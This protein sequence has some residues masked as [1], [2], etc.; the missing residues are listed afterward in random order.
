MPYPVTP[1]A[2]RYPHVSLHLPHSHYTLS[3]R[4]QRGGI[5]TFRSAARGLTNG[6]GKEQPAVT[7]PAARAAPELLAYAHGYAVVA[8]VCSSAQGH[9][10]HEASLFCLSLLQQVLGL[11]LGLGL[12]LWLGFSAWRC[13]NRLALGL[14]IGLGLGLR[15]GC[16]CLL[17]GRNALR[18]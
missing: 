9:H 17:V 15:G 18:S 13:C 16:G 4:P 3:L 11:G 12:G 10:S 8:D 5:L 2:W 7:E 6:G 14:G 1:A